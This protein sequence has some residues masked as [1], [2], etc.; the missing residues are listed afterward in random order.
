[1]SRIDKSI[2]TESRLVVVQGCGEGRE[3]LFKE[4]RFLLDDENALELYNSDACTTW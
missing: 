2:E 3:L 1:M 4:V